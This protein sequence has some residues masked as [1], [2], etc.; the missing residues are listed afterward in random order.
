MKDLID[1]LP[2]L[3]L[4][5]GEVNERLDRMWETNT[6]SSEVASHAIQMNVV[7]HFGF[8]VTEEAAQER[9]NALLKFAQRYPSR[10]IVLCPSESID[11]GSMQAKLFSECYLDEGQGSKTCCEALILSYRPDKCGYLANQVSVWL[12]PDLPVYHWLCGV[13]KERVKGYLDNLLSGVRRVI[14]DSS[15]EGKLLDA[16]DWEDTVTIGDLAAARILPVRQSV[17]QFLSGFD[18][19]TILKGLQTIEV[20]YNERLMGEGHRLLAWVHDCIGAA[21]VNET[22]IKS[23]LNR[24]SSGDA[25]DELTLK[26]AYGDGRHFE[27]RKNA[28][29]MF[30][31][32]KTNLG[33][34]EESFTTRVKTMSPQQA[35]A[36]ALFF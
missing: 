14:Y 33:G 1:V 22:R 15:Y 23:N 24:L 16:L 10:V 34:K 30:G 27:W 21:S 17:G 12:E 18:P 35:I 36:E 11:D 26:F 32:I 3:E 28:K 2:G 31:T 6:P 9:F 19:A 29:G 13:R 8:A 4:P 25:K 5:V 20:G 7:L